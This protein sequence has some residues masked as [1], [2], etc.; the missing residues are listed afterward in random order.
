MA[1]E[2][3]IRIGTRGSALALWQ[4]RHVGDLLA[5]HH[6]GVRAELVTIKTKG[7][8]ILDAPLAKVGGKGL[9]VKEIEQALA[10][11]QVDLAVH[12]AKDM[13]A[14]S[15]DGLCIGAVL[16]REDPRDALVCQKASGLADLPHGAVIG[17]SSLR[18]A[19]QLKLLRPDIRI[20]PLRGNLDTRLSKLTTQ[21]MDA[22]VV[23]AAGM[24]RLGYADRIT[25]WL[26]P[27]TFLPAVGQGA[28]AVQIRTDDP[29]IRPLV[30][31]LDHPDTR[32]AV[33][34]ER[35]FLHRLG[36][37]CQIPVAAF[38]NVL[39]RHPGEGRDQMTLTGLVADTSG[40][41][42]FSRTLDGPVADRLTLG[43]TLAEDLLEQGADKVLEKLVS[44]E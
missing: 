39:G 31:G 6:P 13:P 12:S 2:R 40:D 20:E 4:A 25:Q 33:E 16:P 1:A 22:V 29:D 27:E 24:I 26:D 41:P 21:G 44:Q 5:G 8:K 17:T 10:D 37:S 35:A 28:L 36:G 42:F 9:F 14:E 38:A 15:L 34:A 32:V 19:S 18:R 7:D 23:A 43:R 11:G 3:I 30:E